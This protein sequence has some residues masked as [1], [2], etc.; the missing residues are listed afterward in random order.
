MLDIS[1]N[2]L[3][4][5]FGGLHTI[6]NNTGKTGNTCNTSKTGNT[7]NTSKT[8]HLKELNE[9]IESGF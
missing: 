5:I 3:N 4:P 1:P 6:H 8:A 7:C 2:T 9:S